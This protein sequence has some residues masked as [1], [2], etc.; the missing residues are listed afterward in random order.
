MDRMKFYVYELVD[1]R[2]GTVFYVGK[3]QKNRIDAHERE[4]AK[5]VHS[6]KCDRIRSIW[7]SS[8]E[9]ERHIVSRHE[10]ENEALRAE[11]DLIASYGLVNLTNVLPGGPMEHEVY[12]THLAA[13]SERARLKDHEKIGSDFVSVAPQMAMVLRAKAT[14]NQ[15]GAWVGGRW[16]DFTDAFYALFESIVKSHGCEF[17]R[18]ALAPHGIELREA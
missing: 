5:G 4:A 15:V 13:A 14:G 16:L 7:A 2:D 6:R 10:D 12:L 3:G 9:V 1:P 11:F 18:V 17:V 8:G